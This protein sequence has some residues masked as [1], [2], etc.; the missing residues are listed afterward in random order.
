MSVWQPAQSAA[1]ARYSPRATT[2]RSAA[3]ADAVVSRTAPATAPLTACLFSKTR[4][5]RRRCTC[6]PVNANSKPELLQLCPERVVA[7]VAGV[8]FLK[9]NLGFR[10]VAGLERR[11]QCR[12]L[13]LD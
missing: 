11:A 4:G 10:F 5:T 9:G 6:S 8:E 1:L 12:D 7:G 13:L 3:T 2:S